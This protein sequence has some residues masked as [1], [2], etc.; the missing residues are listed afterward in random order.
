MAPLALVLYKYCRVW[1]TELFIYL[2]CHATLARYVTLR[3]SLIICYDLTECTVPVRGNNW[4][5]LHKWA[6]LSW[7]RKNLCVGKLENFIHLKE[8][9]DVVLLRASLIFSSQKK[10]K[11]KKTLALA[12]GTYNKIYNFDMVH[13]LVTSSSFHIQISIFDVDN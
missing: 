10:R 3:S 11:G 2:F 8:L 1:I 12:D 7:Q 13:K 4:K 5:P 9:V 6:S